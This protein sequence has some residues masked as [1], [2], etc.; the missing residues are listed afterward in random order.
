[1]KE[2][3]RRKWAATSTERNIAWGVAIVSIIL[4]A[5]LIIWPS[6]FSSPEASVEP[7]SQVQQTAPPAEPIT[8]PA[9]Q[10]FKAPAKPEPVAK[11]APAPSPAATPA[12][13]PA[14][15]SESKSLPAPLESKPE[16]ATTSTTPAGYYIQVGAFGSMYRAEQML[17]YVKSKK[18]DARIVKKKNGLNA[19]WVG[20]EP[21]RAKIEE[22]KH[23]MV[24][25]EKLPGYIVQAKK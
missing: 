25:K 12:P 15:K 2:N 19:V 6:L 5:M 21:T 3:R 23:Q 16:P 13:R 11:A 18:F 24:E 20:P 7:A 4:I 1:M 14:P 17:E 8:T 10:A 22:L 9:G